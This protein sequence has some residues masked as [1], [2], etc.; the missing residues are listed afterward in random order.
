MSLWPRSA[1]QPPPAR[2]STVW[3]CAL[4]VLGVA[5][6]LWMLRAA[7]AWAAPAPP[8]WHVVQPGDTVSALAETYGSTVEAIMAANVLPQPDLLNPGQSVIVP[9]AASPLVRVDVQPLQTWTDLARRYNT[10]AADLRA[11]NE[12]AAGERLIPGQVVLVPASLA[13]PSPALPPGP[14]LR[15]VSDPP[16]LRQ[17]ETASLR[18]YLDRTQPV[19]L[20]VT[21]PPQTIVLRRAADGAQWGL[22]AVSALAEPGFMW[23]DVAWQAPGE[24]VSHTLRWPLPVVDGGYPTFNIT[25]PDDKGELLA[26][27]LVQAELERMTALWSAPQTPPVWRRMFLRPVPAQ[28]LTSAPYGQRRS[29]YGGPVSGFHAGQD[30]AA[31]AGTPVI[32]PAAGHVV[33]AE[34]LAVR[35]NAVL[36]DHGGGVFTGYWHLTDIAVQAGQ[37]V[38]PGQLLGHVGTTGLSTGN[39]LHWEMRVNG[40]AVDPLQWLAR[41]FP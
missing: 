6:A 11:L 28:F 30:F 33:L 10:S 26:P 27:D 29:Y 22:A 40:F 12:L 5:C 41:Q 21:L 15:I 2:S 7:P 37:V 38:R 19:S 34:A 39:H 25:L 9:A 31:P 13:A 4:A 18:F 14:I 20:T 16:I 3:L 23:L 35:G 1:Q 8:V 17:G 24:P 36:L 32:A